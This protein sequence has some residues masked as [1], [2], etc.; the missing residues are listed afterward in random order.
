[1]T[2]SPTTA[3]D[4]ADRPVVTTLADGI[5]TIRLNRPAA[6]NS[7]NEAL[8]TALLA[9]LATV[10]G[11]PAARVVV[12]TGTG[13]AFCAGQD[14]KEHLARVR[15]DDPAVATT[16]ADFYNPLITAVTGMRKPV[17]A[18][19]NGVAAGAGAALTFACDQRI[20]A[21]SAS[22]T[23]AFAGVGLS[24]DS[25]ASYFLPRLV[26]TGRAIRMM[27]WGERVSA[28]QA[29]TM[30]MVDEIVADDELMDR[31]AE[32]A[33]QLAAGPAEALAWI[34]AS[35]AYGADHD[36][37]ATLAFEDRAQAACFTSP[38]HREALDAFVAKRSPRF[39]P[40]PGDNHVS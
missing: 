37:A 21:E 6:F 8:K 34:K 40:P 17:L 19:I 39:G 3:P 29:L 13:R 9:D 20:A 31:T 33:G 12:I 5:A 11:D 18:A 26:G 28:E 32:L 2:T 14:L 7:F 25:G 36:L 1:M 22:F 30:G 16:V 15:A 35:V 27:M 10:A 24:A 38:D 4:P 23:L